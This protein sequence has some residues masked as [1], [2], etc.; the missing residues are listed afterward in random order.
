MNEAPLSEAEV[1]EQLSPAQRKRLIRAIEES[2]FDPQPLTVTDDGKIAKDGYG[3]MYV[4]PKGIGGNV[5]VAMTDNGPMRVVK[6]DKAQRKAAKRARCS[7][8]KGIQ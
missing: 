1:I 7:V 4:R 5:R 8:R 6:M 3:R 2:R